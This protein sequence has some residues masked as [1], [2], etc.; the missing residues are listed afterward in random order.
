MSMDLNTDKNFPIT[1][2]NIGLCLLNINKHNQAMDY[3]QQAMKIK[4]QVLLDLNT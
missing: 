4:E 1:L 3:L 2:R